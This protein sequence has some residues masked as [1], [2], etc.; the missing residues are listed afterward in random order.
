MIPIEQILTGA[1]LLILFSI[2]ASKA[3]SRVGLPALVLFLL[4]GIMAGSEG[5]GGIAFDDAATAQSLGIVALAFILFS[6]GLDTEWRAVR[7]IAWAGV[8]LSTIAV[9]L[10]ATTMGI[11]A[12]AILGLSLVEGLLLGAIVSSTDAAAVFSVMR[13][14]GVAL[15]ERV[16]RVLELESGS[17]DPMAIFLTVGLITLIQQPD[18]PVLSLLPM[19]VQQMAIGALVGLGLGRLLVPAINRLNLA[20]DGL[21]LVFTVATVMVVYG[22]ATVLG[23][24][25]FLA[26]YLAGL[27]MGN[28]DF[29]HKRSIMRFHDGLG[30]LMQITMFIT[31]GLLV[32]PSQLL[33]V[34]GAGIVLALLLMFVARPLGVFATLTFSSF[35]RREAGIVAWVGLR[36]AVPIILAT[37]PLVVGI[38]NADLIF[39]VVFFIVVTSVLLQGPLIPLVARWLGVDEPHV[40]RP[41]YP[42]EFEYTTDLDT[43]L[44]EVIVP[45]GSPI[46]GKMILEVGLPESALVVLLHREQA[47]IVPRG[48]T[49]L[50]E[51]DRLLLLADEGAL[52]EVRR[53][54]RDGPSVPSGV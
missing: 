16:K 23:G 43:D 13:A 15:K 1:G 12:T 40:T 37:Y 22:G 11:A 30:W 34:A 48:S 39:N 46:A 35:T 42:L 50:L 4:I 45:K 54:V 27:V 20:Y 24:N 10:T 25:G 19:F 18:T 7:P 44:T 6:G 51:G 31:L 49:S 52:G 26:A 8:G 32:F 36:G 3:S 41:R 17:N 14:R 38:P 28:R 5:I 21:Y 9:V 47:F 2:L 53:L 29:V 33:P